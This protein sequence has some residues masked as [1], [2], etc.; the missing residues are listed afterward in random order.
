VQVPGD[1]PNPVHC[2]FNSFNL[3]S[4]AA[5]LVDYSCNKSLRPLYAVDEPGE[6]T[7]TSSVL[8]FF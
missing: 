6:V 8:P 5:S 1:F 3:R 2:A 7:P 4:V